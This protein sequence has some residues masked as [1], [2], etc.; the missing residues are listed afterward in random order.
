MYAYV[1]AYQ[2]NTREETKDDLLFGV[3]GAQSWKV[4]KDAWFFKGKIE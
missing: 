3:F 2:H 1:S 4:T